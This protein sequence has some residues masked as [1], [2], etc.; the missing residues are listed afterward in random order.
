M[1]AAPSLVAEGLA[2]EDHRSSEDLQPRTA[3][4]LQLVPDL[5]V[6]VQ[7]RKVDS[8]VLM[9]QERSVLGVGRGHQPQASSP[10]VF[11]KRL[12]LVAGR[13]PLL[14][15]QEPDLV[16]MDRFGRRTG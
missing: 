10:L 11:G 14:V 15:R 2:V 7:R 6:G 3:T 13:K 5:L 9:D 4:R 16:E 1:M 8:G 12:L